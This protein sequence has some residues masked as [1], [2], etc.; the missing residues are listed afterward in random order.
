VD[1]RLIAGV[2]RF[3]AGPMP[4]ARLALYRINCFKLPEDA[5]KVIRHFQPEGTV[6]R[7]MMNPAWKRDAPLPTV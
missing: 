4:T 1:A 2:R 5:M 7:W 6:Q 3:V